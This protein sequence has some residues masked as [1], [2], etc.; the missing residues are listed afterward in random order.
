MPNWFFS[1]QFRLIVGFAII[2]ALAVGSLNAYIGYTAQREVE[3]IERRFDLAR[4][5][6]VRR[7]LAQFYIANGGWSGVQALIERAAFLS[8][9]EIIV[10]DDSGSVVLGDTRALQDRL[11]EVAPS[12]H[13]FLPVTVADRAVGSVWVSPT[14]ARPGIPRRFRG[15]GGPAPPQAPLEFGDPQL[16]EFA[17]A[18]NRSLVWAGLAAGTSGLLLV[19][20]VSRRFL[21]SV[22]GLTSA[23]RELGH[24]DLSQ[25]V[26]AGGR[27]EMGELGRTFN[28]MADGLQ[29]AERQRRNMVAD[30]AHEL[31]TPLSNIQ[32]YTEAIRDGLLQPDHTTLETIHQQVQSLS[33]LIDDLQLLSD[34]EAEDFRLSRELESLDEVVRAA[35]EAFRPRAEAQG[36]ALDFELVGEQF[37]VSLDRMRIEQVIGNLLENAITYTLSGGRITVSV[38]A[39]DTSAGPAV[40]IADTGEGI[41]PELLPYVFERFYRVDP[42]RARATGGAGLGLTIAKQLVEAHGG[43]IHAESEPGVGSRFVFELPKDPK[44]A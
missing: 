36:V 30:V 31:R 10:R 23:A 8:D 13:R 15:R 9:R 42:S 41:S 1:L 28:S 40:A 26:E 43:S 7:T 25:R 4:S 18:I 2:L 22:R 34:A 32:G 12:D 16:I 17:E 39:E 21:R 3:K 19:S 11:P 5:S 24:G 35:T 14:R 6:R 29:D 38:S 20:L 33:R 27:D 44:P 37:L